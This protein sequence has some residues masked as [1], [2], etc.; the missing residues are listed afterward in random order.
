[1]KVL[2]NQKQKKSFL[3]RLAV[4]IFGAYMLV[5]LVNQQI[6]IQGKRQELTAAKQQIQI[7]E[8]KNDDLKQAFSTGADDERDYMERKARE[9]LNYAKPGERVFVNIAGH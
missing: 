3:L 1:M 8:I 4:F 7:Q 9:E 6:E 5:A 2:E